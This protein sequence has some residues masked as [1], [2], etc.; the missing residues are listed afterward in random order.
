MSDIAPIDQSLLPAD[1]RAGSGAD[2][3]RYASALSFEK[4]L[5]TQLTQQMA[6]TTKP[7]GDDGDD[8]GSSSAAT[9]T[10]QQMLPGVM[11][12]AITSAGGLG[13]ARQLYD[14]LKASGA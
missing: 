10:Y 1:V 8:A 12:D 14:G 6:D 11:A 3:D 4:M 7:S 2:K 13:I 9:S 5:V